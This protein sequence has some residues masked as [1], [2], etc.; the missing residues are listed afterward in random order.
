M[1]FDANYT[2][3]PQDGPIV[4]SIISER[5]KGN[6]IR[7]DL[8]D[9]YGQVNIQEKYKK[10][11]AD[12]V[13]VANA[14]VQKQLQAIGLGHLQAF[15]SLV[16]SENKVLDDIYQV[17]AY[18]KFIVPV[19]QKVSESFEDLY[20]KISPVLDAKSKATGMIKIAKAMRKGDRALR[21]T[22]NEEGKELSK[23][24]LQDALIDL[25]NPWNSAG[26]IVN[27]VSD[28]MYEK[29]IEE[30]TSFSHSVCK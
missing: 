22:L 8:C 30:I 11:I 20:D 27:K 17:I 6:K 10:I 2:V 5:A 12:R 7:T 13:N 18:Q 16:K 23:D 19:S 3:A 24:Q 25:N 9:M 15:L 29:K 21:H 28:A 1:L 26:Y 4:D 14:C